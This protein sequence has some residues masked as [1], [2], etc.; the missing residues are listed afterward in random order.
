VRLKT[1]KKNG[2]QTQLPVCTETEDAASWDSGHEQG[3]GNKGALGA[4]DSAHIL[5]CPDV[6]T[7]RTVEEMDWGVALCIGWPRGQPGVQPGLL[8]RS[9]ASAY[10]CCLPLTHRKQSNEPPTSNSPPTFDSACIK[11]ACWHSDNNFILNF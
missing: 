7:E 5:G 10:V 8:P 2:Q 4:G 9:W 6:D 1:S 11:T 3:R